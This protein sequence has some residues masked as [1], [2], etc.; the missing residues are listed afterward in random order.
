MWADIKKNAT[1]VTAISF[2]PCVLWWYIAYLNGDSFQ[3]YAVAL[4]LVIGWVYSVNFL[5]MFKNVDL[6]VHTLKYVIVHDIVYVALVA[7]FFLIGFSTGMAALI[8]LSPTMRSQYPSYG[9]AMY[10]TFLLTY[11]LD[12]IITPTD[13]IDAEYVSVDSDSGL[14]LSFIIAYVVMAMIFINILIARM[15]DTYS[16]IR[17]QEG[18]TWALASIRHGFRLSQIRKQYFPRIFYPDRKKSMGVYQVSHSW[19]NAASEMRYYIT[20]PANNVNQGKN[21]DLKIE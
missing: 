4:A 21:N 5:R 7:M 17:K 14:L 3:A 13:D 11:G 12:H 10:A 6:F 1:T 15:T 8:Q 19:G 16:W 2:F 20:V 18:T 9:D